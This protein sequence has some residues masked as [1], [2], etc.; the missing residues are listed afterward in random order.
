MATSTH[1]TN[2]R[3]RMLDRDEER[4]YLKRWRRNRD[5]AALD[6]LIAAHRPL[7]LKLAARYRGFGLNTDDLVQE[8]FTGLI[9][10]ANRFDLDQPVRFA[11]YAHWW[12]KAAIQDFVLRNWSAVRPVTSSRQKRAF[13]AL[14]RMLPSLAPDGRLDDGAEGELA[15]QLGIGPEALDDMVRRVRATAS[16]LN[17][18]VGAESGTELMDLL[19]D[20]A[21]NPEDIVV[22][23]REDGARSAWLRDALKGL[24]PRERAIIVE[25]HLTED[26]PILADL[27]RRFGVSKERVRQIEKRALDK[28]HRAARRL[29]PHSV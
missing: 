22:A 12:A 11:T 4:A 3:V 6:A 27:G 10:A 19:A 18:P 16:S 5:A 8:G 20:D 24:D 23:E 1:P 9:E 7:V 25:R 29:E 21:P 17:A 2:R 28:L 26:G 13:F 15:R 14:K